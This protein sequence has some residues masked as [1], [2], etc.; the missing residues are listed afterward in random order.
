[1]FVVQICSNHHFCRVHHQCS[2]F[3][4]GSNSILSPFRPGKTHPATPSLPGPRRTFS[5]SANSPGFAC[6]RPLKTPLMWRMLN[7]AD[8]TFLVSWVILNL[9]TG[10]RNMTTDNWWNILEFKFVE[11][12][13]LFVYRN[14]SN[15]NRSGDFVYDFGRMFFEKY[16]QNVT[17]RNLSISAGIPFGPPDTAAVISPCFSEKI[18]PQTLYIAAF[19]WLFQ[20]FKHIW[21]ESQRMD[22]HWASLVDRDFDPGDLQYFSRSPVVKKKTGICEL[23]PS[24]YFLTWRMKMVH[25][26]I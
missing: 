10:E 9:K 25:L 23:I 8:P 14:W 12:T 26:E 18:I 3:F 17:T 7:L 11:A 21:V 4:L 22:S 6:S 16:W 15:K 13:F 5:A 19:V 20:D 24:S 2:P 1:M